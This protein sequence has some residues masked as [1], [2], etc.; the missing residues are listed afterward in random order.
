VRGRGCRQSVLRASAPPSAIT[1]L[2]LTLVFAS[3]A[4]LFAEQSKLVYPGPDGRLVY[5][6]HAHD[7]EQ[8]A[9]HTIPD[10]SYAGYRGGGVRLPDV[11]VKETVLPG[12]GNDGQRIQAAIDKVSASPLDENGLRGAVLIKAGVYDLEPHQDKRSK[13]ALTI[14]ASGV[15]LRGEGQGEGG[16]VL[17][18]SQPVAH[19]G[20]LAKPEKPP[21]FTEEAL[22]RITDPIVG[23]GARSFHVE[24]ARDYA[25]GDAIR[26]YFTPNE[27][28]IE[29]IN[30]NGYMNL[31]QG[32]TSEP[33]T[34]GYFRMHSDRI[35]TAIDGN[36]ITID[37]PIVTPLK[38]IHGGG[39]IAKLTLASGEYLTNVGI[40]SLRFEGPG[41]S[42]AAPADSHERLE[43]G[44]AMR[45]VK[46]SWVKNFTV[47]HQHDACVDLEDC[48]YLT[49]ED[50]RSL[51]PIGR[52]EG[53]QRYTW[54]LEKDVS[55]VLVQRCYSYDGRHCYV[56]Q[57][58]VSGPNVFLDNV[59]RKDSGPM[60]PHHR[61]STGGLFDCLNIDSR[62]IPAEHAGSRGNNHSWTGVDQVAWN[63]VANVFANDTPLGY[64]N[65][66]IGGIGNI[67]PSNQVSNDK[68]GVHAGYT[69]HHGTHVEPRSLYLKQLEDRLG[70]KAVEN[71]TTPSQR[72][73]FIWHE[74]MES[75]KERQ[76]YY[77]V[78]ATDDVSIGRQVEPTGK[79]P[80]LTVFGSG[81]ASKRSLGFM[82]FD[83]GH[84]PLDDIKK[85]KL[86]L[87][88]R[89]KDAPP[90]TVSGSLITDWNEG[91]AAPLQTP[92]ELI[93]IATAKP[94]F[95]PLDE[96]ETEFTE[97]DVTS[98]INQNKGKSLRF[99]FVVSD[100]GAT[101]QE[102]KIHS[103]EENEN[104][105]RYTMPYLVVE[106]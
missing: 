77:K 50:N 47:L 19:T 17:R 59:A 8:E 78:G 33:W 51:K 38:G 20:I 1:R 86:L 97:F 70:S 100:D 44:I 104:V 72:K 28:W 89:T 6:P 23:A 40:E 11:S 15:V 2:A 14:Q 41:I 76:P 84:V 75:V 39:E 91:N 66:L 98:W 87:E 26:I 43:D 93:K 81:D 48:R 82:R 73:R 94:R 32:Q 54:R 4:Q 80:M 42:E 83:L 90:L 31:I 30:A 49:I 22:T 106:Y 34:T 9:V 69:E 64:Q 92:Q 85:V 57:A 29:D 37:S 53:G 16:T 74:I 27:K 36:K 56:T 35:I 3:L 7:G 18:V 61:W 62:M 102:V 79:E 88:V 45:Y 60:G 55:H 103:K 13:A 5:T 95:G 68:P 12:L 63:C 101:E 58:K 67:F 46:D 96:G 52:K 10:F 21:V 105:Y 25:A 65:Y 99:T 24:N 71:V